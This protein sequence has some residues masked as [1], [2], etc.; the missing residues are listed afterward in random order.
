[1]TKLQAILIIA[2]VTMAIFFFSG[3]ALS[4]PENG[5]LGYSACISCHV[6]PSGGG[7]LTQ[8]GR[9]AQ[10]EFMSTWSYPGAESATMGL[11]KEPEWAMVGGDTRYLVRDLDSEF[12]RVLMQVD[13]EAALNF[14][15]QIAVV[16]AYGW[17]NVPTDYSR[18]VAEGLSPRH[19]LLLK[20]NKYLTFRYGQFVPAYGLMIADHTANIRRE[21]NVP[22][23]AA[24]IGV[25]SEYGELLVT[26]QKTA[27]LSWYAGQASQIG[28]SY[29]PDRYGF[30][31][32]AGLP[33]NMFI[34]EQMDFLHNRQVHLTKL[35]IQVTKG[36]LLFGGQEDRQWV[37]ETQWFPFPHL[38]LFLS[39]RDNDF[40]ALVHWNL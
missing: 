40:R 37:A 11:V 6:S 2:I 27:R 25:F 23:V 18:P 24:E 7:I 34:L 13:F 21:I 35:G 10:A 1:M 8:Y 20:P 12:R 33:W 30:F 14:S 15:D 32:V 36:L 39:A 9:S 31:S 4:Y 16:G 29:R 17:Y 22:V 28:L 38:E 19:Y 5:R 3:F 26:D